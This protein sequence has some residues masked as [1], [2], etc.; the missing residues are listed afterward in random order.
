MTVCSSGQREGLLSGSLELVRYNAGRP[1][2]MYN[3]TLKSKGTFQNIFEQT[4]TLIIVAIK[5]GSVTA[6]LRHPIPQVYATLT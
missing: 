2:I 4:N 1:F 3:L 6:F 5:Q